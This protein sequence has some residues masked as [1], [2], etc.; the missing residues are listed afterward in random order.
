[1]VPVEQRQAACHV[2]GPLHLRRLLREPGCRQSPFGEFRWR[3]ER[4]NR[5][6]PSTARTADRSLL[7]GSSLCESAQNEYR[8]VS[9]PPLSPVSAAWSVFP[10]AGC[11]L[12][13]LV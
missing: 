8:L 13:A 1:T 5:L 4:K 11:L 7:S 10:F 6:R 3:P 12:T 2:I 9:L